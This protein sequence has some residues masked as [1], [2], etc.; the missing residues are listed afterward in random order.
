MNADLAASYEA[1]RNIY[2]NHAYSNLAAGEAI[3]HHPGC[4]GSFVRSAVKETLRQ[5]FLLDH[6]VAALSKNGL[7]GMKSRTLV[8]LRLGLRLLEL[9]TGIPDAVI[10]HEIVELAR[11]KAQG[12][13]GFVNAVLRS[14]LRERGSLRVPEGMSA[15][16]LSVRYS[17]HTALVR[18][19][20][21]QYGETDGIRLME[22]LNAP[23]EV[24]LRVNLLRGTRED[25]LREL[26]EAGVSAHLSGEC[27]TGLVLESGNVIGQDGFRNGRYSVQ[28]IAS[29][30]A[31]EALSPEP[32]SRV[33]DLCAAPGG[34]T[35]AIAERMEDRVSITACDLHE[36]RAD[37]I[38]KNAERLG[39]TSIHAECRDAAVPVP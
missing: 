22:A 10:V 11:K 28:G 37:L 35:A 23:C 7:R 15:E 30:M 12:S 14:Y 26:S 8:L 13:H 21:S 9:E 33:L 39:L 19:I 25:V 18:M 32:G 29:Q 31:V 4:S 5:T 16:A 24:G 17:V 34:K 27:E 36:Q 2:T 38:L 20:L 3:G 1:L 6:Y